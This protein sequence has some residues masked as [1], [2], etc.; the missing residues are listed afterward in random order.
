VI[1]QNNSTFLDPGNE[2]IQLFIAL[3]EKASALETVDQ[4]HPSLIFQ[5]KA[6][7]NARLEPTQSDFN[8]LSKMFY[9]TAPKPLEN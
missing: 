6:G 4:F 3:I 8:D 9:N 5:G 7:A 1:Q 2:S